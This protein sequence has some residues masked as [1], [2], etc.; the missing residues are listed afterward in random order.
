[1]IRARSATIRRKEMDAVLTCMVDERIGPGEMNARLLQTAKEFFK[2]DGAAAFR[3]PAVAL[4]YALKSLDIP[5]GAPVMVS[6]LAPSWQAFAIEESGFKVLP[7]DVDDSSALVKAETAERAVKEGGAVLIAH[8]AQG[9]MPDMDALCALGVPV[10]ED[11][12]QSAGASIAPADG[13]GPSRAAGS[14]GSCAVLG[15]E[16]GDAVTAGGGALLMAGERKN[17]AAI[18]KLTDGAPRVELLP[19]LN[20]ALALVE[21]KE[22]NRNEAARKELFAFYQRALMSG[23]NKILSRDIEGGDAAFSFPVALK[24]SFKDARQYAEKKGVELRLAFEDSIIAR[25]EAEL[26]PLRLVAAKSLMLRCV[27]FPLYPRLTKQ[28]SAKAA[29]VLGTLP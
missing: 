25:R 27:L 20:A 21:L 13:Q 16:E 9:A 14:F 29:K 23:S 5:A 7:L 2:F 8:E 1:M 4:K 22:F 6:A 19:D 12:S 15:L 24:S 26:S 17:W 11:I 18:K 10:I 28:Q 3:S